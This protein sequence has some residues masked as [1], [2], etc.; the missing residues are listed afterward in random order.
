MIPL[1]TGWGE[2]ALRVSTPRRKQIKSFSLVNSRAR[3]ESE[4]FEW[5]N[6]RPEL[7]FLGAKRRDEKATPGLEFDK[8]QVSIREQGLRGIEL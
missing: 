5:R 8:S 1:Q 7:F 2:T 4:T 3:R 6:N